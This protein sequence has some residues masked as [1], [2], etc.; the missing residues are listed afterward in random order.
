MQK[1]KDRPNWDKTKHGLRNII[2]FALKARV[3]SGEE[4]KKKKEE[5][6]KKKIKE[7]GRREEQED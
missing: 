2:F 3:T 7:E 5:E 6:K 1:W 4:K